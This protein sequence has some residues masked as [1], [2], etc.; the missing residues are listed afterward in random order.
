MDIKIDFGGQ[1]ADLK[2]IQKS[3]IKQTNYVELKDGSI[4][5]L[6]KEW[7]ENTRSTLNLGT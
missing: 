2:Q 3:I 5:I 1:T 6:P 4:G 7:I